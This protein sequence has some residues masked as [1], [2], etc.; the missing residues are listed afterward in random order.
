MTARIARL[1]LAVLCGAFGSASHAQ[2]PQAGFVLEW[3]E[4]KPLPD[5]VGVAGPFVGVAGGA[6]IVAGGANFPEKAPWEG[7]TKVWHDS[8]FVLTEPEG[9]WKTGFR[10]P[11]PAAYGITVSLNKGMVCVGG[12]DAKQVFG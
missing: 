6:L 3:D 7:G 9:E 11:Q 4:L 5:P 10:L 1:I 12:G 2:P 8:V